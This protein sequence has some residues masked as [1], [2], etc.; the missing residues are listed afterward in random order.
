MILRPVLVAVCTT[1]LLACAAAP[2]YQRP[3]LDLPLAW[4]LEAPWRVGQPNDTASK[5]DWWRIFGD[6]TLDTLQ[7]QALQNSPTLALAQARLLQARATLAATSASALPQLGLSERVSRQKISANRPLSNYASPNSST[8]QNELSVAMTVNYELDLAGRVEQSTAGARAS[9][10][11]AAAELENTRLLLSADLAANYFNLREIDAELDVLDRATGLQR[12]ALELVSA[13]RELGA[14]SGLDVAQQQALLETTLVQLELL[15]RQRGQFE[16]AIATL[17]G[18]AA[19]QFSLAPERRQQLAPPVPL[20]LPSELLQRRP[21]IAA[22]ER[23]M[24]AANAQIGVAN[25]AFYPS[26][27]L[28]SVLGADSRELASLFD[29]PSLL[30]SLGLSAAQTIFDGGRLRANLDF[31]RAGYDATVANYRRVVLLAMQEVEDG[32]T[33]LTALRRASLQ[34]AT[35]RAAA[36]RV[37]E[38]T[39]AR[40]D[41][42]L[43]PY[44]EL[45]TAQQALL[46]SERQSVQLLGQ[47]LVTT[48]FLIKA[49]GGSIPD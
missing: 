1:V 19:P 11:Q 39:R 24:A 15:R 5:G 31:S 9:A 41:G 14:G 10:A 23:A 46:L 29:A 40:Y 6:A 45:V 27:V 18:A 49:L 44:L 33:G 22:A 35:A 16:H 3:A 20:G 7:Q 47:E 36:Q 25:A 8:V 38:M 37:L 28:G 12:R 42:G 32:I 17:T 43:S 4:K 34:A 48:V 21:D 2:E 26:I 13:R 30:W